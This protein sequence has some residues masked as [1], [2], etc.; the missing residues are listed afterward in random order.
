M[1]WLPFIAV[2]VVWSLYGV[3]H[4][5]ENTPRIM[6]LPQWRQWLV[7]VAAGP[8]AWLCILWSLIDW[9]RDWVRW[10]WAMYQARR[11]LR[12]IERQIEDVRRGR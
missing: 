1:T 4:V 12:D 9:S 5:F 2:C 7:L 10:H 11:E 6:A 8:L 3:V